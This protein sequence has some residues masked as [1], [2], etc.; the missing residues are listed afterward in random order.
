MITGSIAIAFV[1]I[2]TIMDIL[3]RRHS[4]KRPH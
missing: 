4:R 1:L 3:E 2:A